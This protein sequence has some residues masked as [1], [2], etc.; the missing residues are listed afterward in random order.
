MSELGYLVLGFAPGLFWLWTIYQRDR[1]L[2]S[3]LSLVIR[4]FLYGVLASVPIVVVETALSGF[5]AI[6]INETGNSLGTM[7]YVAFIVAGATEELGKFLVV[8]QTLYRS[9]YFSEPMDGL[10]FAAA[11]ALG[12]ASI[13]NVG[14]MVVFGAGVVLL[15]GV[16]S[17]VGHVVFAAPWGY[18]L[19]RQKRGSPYGA[20]VTWAAL[21]V[22]ITA[23]GLFDFFLFA[24]GRWAAGTLAIFFAGLV[25]LFYLVSLADAVSAR[26][27]R[28]ASVIL[29]CA[30]CATRCGSRASYCPACGEAFRTAAAAPLGSCGMCEAVVQPEFRFCPECGSLLQRKNLEPY[31]LA[32][33][34]DGAPAVRPQPGRQ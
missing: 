4:T 7:V 10:I 1:Y 2:P 24:G 5:G 27:H 32:Q 19:G 11:A 29:T 13:E 3:P 22:G 20:P 15:R 28:S 14:Y 30:G 18:A 9:P 34:P 12:F 16:F 31:T 23:H 25:G 17:T 6:E 26:L 21:A 33:P 8:R